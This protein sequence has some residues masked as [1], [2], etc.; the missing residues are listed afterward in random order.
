MQASLNSI[1]FLGLFLFI[2]GLISCNK[3]EVEKE[4]VYYIN[5]NEARGSQKTLLSEA[6]PETFEILS[7][8]EY[9]KDINW[10]YFQGAIIP[11]A[12]AK[13]FEFIEDLYAKDKNRAYYGGDSIEGS[14]SKGFRVIDSYYS[15]DFKDVYYT[16]KPLHV[17][18]T[19]T[20]K[21]FENQNKENLYQRWSTDGCFYYFE[22]Y[23]VPSTD[24]KDVY[25]F[26]ESA[27]FAK[28]K[29]WVYLEGRK[30]NYNEQGVLIIDT[31]DS[32]SFMVTNYIECKDKFGCINPYLGRKACN[33]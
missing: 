24:Y 9:G 14:S 20:F 1:K 12:D 16:N 33:E 5:W 21:I 3:Y 10:V 30:L 15:A 32:K 29:E 23:K 19:Q 27:G 11:G 13:S 17:C 25:I 18:G 4:G 28:D 2:L 6:D 31:I 26:K 8:E 22:H 7:Q